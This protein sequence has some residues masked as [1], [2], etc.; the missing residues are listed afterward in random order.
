MR[1][2]LHPTIPGGTDLA[3]LALRVIAGI[4]L[5]AHGWQKLDEFTP[6]GTEAFLGDA[7]VP[8]A[9][10][11]A[12]W[13]II[14]EIGGGIALLLGVLTPVVAL[15]GIAN[16][17]GAIAFVHAGNGL[18]VAAGGVELVLLLIA[19]LAPLALLGAGR[20]SVDRFIAAPAR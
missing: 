2:L 8:L 10:I 18:F 13:L 14:T 12:W 4:V 16:M 20:L 5:I 17:I 1:A 3:L 19:T 11:A 9:G 7:G 15:I 6:A